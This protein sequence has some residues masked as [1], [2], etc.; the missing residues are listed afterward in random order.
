[1]C[2][3]YEANPRKDEWMQLKEEDLSGEEMSLLARLQ[4]GLTTDDAAMTK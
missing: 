4:F 1:M 3:T 2:D